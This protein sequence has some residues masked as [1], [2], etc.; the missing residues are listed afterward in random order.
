MCTEIVIKIGVLTPHAAVGPEAEFA[1]MAPG[2]LVT[3]MARIQDQRQSGDPATAAA[4]ASLT[5]PALLDRGVD[6]LLADQIEVI[7]Y[8][9]TTTAYVLGVDAE[10]AMVTRL[11]QRSRLPVV[12]TCSAAADALRTLQVQRVA[13]FGAPW[14]APEFNELG[15]GCFASQGFEVVCST[16]A[17]LTP[18]PNAIEAGAV[19]D[20]IASHV[21]DA[22]EAVYI[23]GNGFRT[24]GAIEPLEQALD[25]PVL[26]ANQVLLWQL[27]AAAHLSFAVTGFGR[28][29]DRSSRA[30]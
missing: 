12:A 2:R 14:F 1:A 20:W 23:G 30:I 19:T 28:L 4:L 10:Q 24:V 29:F 18:D 8:A 25:L 15:A 16:S 7:G 27:L 17:E 21:P 3:R 26:T 22:A 6:M 5:A 11:A 13:L 9:S